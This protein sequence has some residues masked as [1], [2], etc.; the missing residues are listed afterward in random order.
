VPN[1][2]AWSTQQLAEF[3][4]A[5]S[6]VDEQAGAGRVAVERAAEA[7]E[8]EVAAIVRDGVVEASVGYP[9]AAIPVEELAAAADGSRNTLDVPGAGQCFAVSVALGDVSPGRLVAARSDEFDQDEV[10]LLRSMARVLALT[11]ETLRVVD[12]ERGLRHE[13][14]LQAA[15]NFAL[16]SDLTERQALLERLSDIQRAIVRR[17]DPQVV[18]EAI[19]DGAATHVRGDAAFIRLVDTDDPGSAFIV[20]SAGLDADLLEN[21]RRQPVGR[22]ASGRAIATGEPVEINQYNVDSR[23]N[24]EPAMRGARAAISA[25]VHRQGRVVGS[26]T[27]ASLKPARDYQDA[28]RNAVLAFAEHASIALTDAAMVDE[29]FHRAFHDSLTGLANR[30]LFLDRLEHALAGGARTEAYV[31]FLDLDGF[32]TVNDSLGHATGDDLL[33]AVSDRLRTCLRPGDTVARFGG[34]EFAILLEC[35]EGLG[36]AAAIAD[37]VL[38]DLRAPFT[39]AGRE[40]LVSASIGIAAADGS[41]EEVLRNADLAMYRSKAAGKD[42]YQ[43]FAPEMHAEVIDRLELEADLRRAIDAGQFL[44]HYQPIFDLASGELVSAEALIRWNHPRRGLV[45]PCEF[46]PLAEETKLIRDIGRWVLSEACM[47]AASWKREHGRTGVS[48]NLSSVQLEFAQIVPEVSAAL[49]ESGLDPG[50][51][52]LEITETVLMRDISA[53]VTTLQQLKQLGVRLA[54]DDFGTGYSSLQYLGGFPLD[55]LKMA[56]PFVDGLRG[57]APGLALARV[58][59]G[60]GESL[61]LA[62]VAEGIET[63]DQYDQLLELGCRYGQGFLL[64]RPA[65]PEAIGDLLRRAR[66]KRGGG[67]ERKVDSSPARA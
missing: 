23:A 40:V 16:L 18:L 55:W 59:A 54:V 19:V 44:L 22:G 50:D 12:N 63:D 21:T 5:V 53:T 61:G 3:L 26:L 4:A 20:A 60:L 9:A 37:R 45:P 25:P 41:G 66:V 62:V 49:E 14:E 15:E 47:Q 42:C 46:I 7:L 64:A 34:D 29:A 51:L 30:A 56:K 38:G 52:V 48:V 2:L 13:S 10:V 28:E 36:E 8:A 35:A 1:S 57:E 39:V 58:I 27:V 67:L 32:K 11:Q 24:S 65:D 33:V 31:L 43:L 17:A 6:A